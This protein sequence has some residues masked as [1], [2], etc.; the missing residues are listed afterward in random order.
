M[1]NSFKKRKIE[2]EAFF[3]W[4]CDG[5]GLGPLKKTLGPI[6]FLKCNSF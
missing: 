2:L 3:P 4:A 6:I 1:K 5:K